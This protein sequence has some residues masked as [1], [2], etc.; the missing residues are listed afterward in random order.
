MKKFTTIVLAAGALAIAVPA[1]A[2]DRLG[3]G[4]RQHPNKQSRRPDQGPQG[5]VEG[6]SIDQQASEGGEKVSP[7]RAFGAPVEMTVT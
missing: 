5:R 3:V 7:L 1:L 2:A 4:G 6:P